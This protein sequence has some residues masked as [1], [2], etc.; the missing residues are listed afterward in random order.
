M[1]AL[2]PPNVESELS[3]AYLHAV[4]SHAG[5]S[6]EVAGRHE[7]NN[8]TDARLTS[9]GPFKPA[10]Y[11]TEVT[12]KV[13]LKATVA[14]PVDDGANL[15]YFL[16]G[17]NQYDDLR[18]ETISSARILVVLFLPNNSSDW[19][20]HSMEQLSLR[21]CAYWQS[22]RGAPKSSNGSGATIKLP[23][24]QVFNVASLQDLAS[25]LSR[26]DFPI[27]PTK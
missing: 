4:A 17:I 5:V 3:Y 15:S 18:C 14:V 19:L 6:C 1:R 23:K 11:L 7:D 2:A 26:S 12:I 21:R 10:G 9:W 27:Y 20:D 22:L 8:G 13:Q 24:T 25:R 16:K